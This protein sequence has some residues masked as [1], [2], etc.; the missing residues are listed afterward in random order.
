MTSRELTRESNEYN[1]VIS[2]S[3]SFET[4]H[5]WRSV[6]EMDRRG[7][8]RDFYAILTIYLVSLFPFFLFF[9]FSHRARL[10]MLDYVRGSSEKSYDTSSTRLIVIIVQVDHIFVISNQ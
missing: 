9:F 3:F 2:I 7:G 8:E 1:R 10:T 4:F 6:L 5:K